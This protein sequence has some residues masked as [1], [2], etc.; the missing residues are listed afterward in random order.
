[1]SGKIFLFTWPDKYSLN[2]ELQFWASS[3]RQK[4]WEDS[5]DTYNSENWDSNKVNQSVFGWW[6][7]V[8][9]KM[10]IIKWLPVPTEKGTWF[11][12][13]V[14]WWFTENFMKNYA[15]IPNDNIIIFVS[16]NPDKRW[17]FFKF[18]Q[19]EFCN[20]KEYNPIST[21]QLKSKI[22]QEFGDIKI[23]ENEINFFID[24]VGTDLYQVM[25]EIDKVK[26]Y[27]KV[28]NINEVS[29][30]MIEDIVFWLTD[31]NVFAFLNLAFVDT[32]GAI[33]Y[34]EKIEESGMTWIEFA[35]AIYSQLK[36]SIMIYRLYEQGIKDWKEIASQCG[37]NPAAV[38]VN[39][40]NIK[41][42]SKNWLELENMYKYLV[43]TDINIKSGI[44]E[45]TE[46]RLNTKKM[47]TKFKK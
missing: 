13:D 12:A 24:T 11:T 7:F 36:S 46:F 1:M 31:S 42:I 43:Q 19:N 41:E 3:F 32:L 20:I 38:F 9:K 4:Y 25:S 23:A 35:W 27:C 18:F 47:I 5:V 6:L 33:K 29:H 14:I 2:Q 26:E 17:K 44:N 30:K 8:V 21:I 40:K 22:K 39:L 28:H 34:L 45:D 16:P 37:L 15:Q 10:T